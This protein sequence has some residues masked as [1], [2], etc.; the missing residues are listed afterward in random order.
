MVIAKAG[1]PGAIGQS[2]TSLGLPGQ[3]QVNLVQIHQAQLD[4]SLQNVL[5]NKQMQP[6]PKNGILASYAFNQH[7]P[8][9]TNSQH[10]YNIRSNKNQSHSV[11]ELIKDK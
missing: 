6:F 5:G 4:S 7:G 1:G 9:A 3:Q 8:R 2:Q 11:S 10:Q